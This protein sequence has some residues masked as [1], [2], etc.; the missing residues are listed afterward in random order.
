MPAA[1]SSDQQCKVHGSSLI[2][3]VSNYCH[4]AP[5]LYFKLFVSTSSCSFT[6]TSPLSFLIYAITLAK[7]RKEPPCP[8]LN[9]L[10]FLPRS[11]EFLSL[12]IYIPLSAQSYHSCLHLPIAGINGMSHHCLVCMADECGCFAL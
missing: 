1:I 10:E 6:S 3:L 9:V 8:S 4:S 7:S 12:P 2:A 5:T 11:S